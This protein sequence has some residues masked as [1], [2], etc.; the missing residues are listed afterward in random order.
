VSYNEKLALL[1]RHYHARLLASGARDVLQ[2]RSV[3]EAL[4]ENSRAA[5]D[6]MR[7]ALIIA[8][9]P[10]G[11]AVLALGR[12]GTREHDL[13]SDA[14]LIFVRDEAAEA[15]GARRVAERIV[16]IL[17]AYTR[18]GSVFPVDTRLRPR[19]GEGEFVV[20]PAQLRTYFQREA[21][22]WEALIYTKL[23]FLAGACEVAQQVAT[24]VNDLLQ[25]FAADPEFSP[26]VRE[27]RA[28]LQKSGEET[29]NLKTGAGGLYDI[30]FLISA[31][32]VRHGLEST[33]GN[34]RQKLASLLERGLLSAEDVQKLHRHVDLL[35][36][37]EHVIRL[38]TGRHQ[39][40]L[41]VSGAA[42]AACEDL[43]TRMLHRD[44][45]EGL[46]ISLRFALVGV[47]QI[48]TRL[49]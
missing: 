30:D 14:D 49:A 40:T 45:P 18:E 25:R 41:P 4:D 16:E 24:A 2:P 38:V 23:R 22:P 34:L 36:T 27:M 28:R 26:N 19:G 11:F 43:C 48:Y 31:Q 7:A 5:E 6:A 20:T 42:R 46:E 39:A 8:E 15:Q 35:R 32:L 17:S 1:R 37:A 47:R 21:Q 13:L 33:Q 9:A 29:D 3:W 12:L 44:F 10:P